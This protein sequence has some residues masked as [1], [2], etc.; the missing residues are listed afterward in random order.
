MKDVM[1]QELKVGDTVVSIFDG[2]KV[3]VRCV[4]MKI[5]KQK[6]GLMTYEEA[7]DLATATEVR[8]KRLKVRYKFP[9]QVAKVEVKAFK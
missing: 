3:L 1:G 5:S 7:K 6:V 8:F 9:E 2:Y 4:V